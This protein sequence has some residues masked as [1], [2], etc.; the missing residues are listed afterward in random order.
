MKKLVIWGTSGHGKVVLD[1]VQA[2]QE[3]S[4][5]VFLDDAGPGIGDVFMGCSVAGRRDQLPVLRG[6]EFLIAIGSNVVRSDCFFEAVAQGLRPAIAVH[7]SAIVS[8]FAS[9]GA[10][11]VV[12]PR[13]VINAG[14]TIGVD[15]ILNTGVIVEHDCVIGDHAHLSPGVVLGG[16]ATIGAFVHVGLNASALPLANIGESAVI[17]AGAVVLKL[18]APGETVAGVPAKPLK[19][20]HLSQR[21]I[22]LP[23]VVK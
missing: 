9:I 8:R 18:V 5:I 3:W 6:A 11:T 12:L 23:E 1:V 17:G 14:A 19:V 4:Q 22:L 10:G 2:L 20:G 13:A 15:C 21:A 16:G 7:P